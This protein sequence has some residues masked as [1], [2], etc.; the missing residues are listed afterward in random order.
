MGLDMAMIEISCL[1]PLDILLTQG[2][3]KSSTFIRIG[4]TLA[5]GGRTAR[6]SHASLVVAPSLLVESLG[7]GGTAFTSLV[8]TDQTRL[9]ARVDGRRLRLFAR[10]KDVKAGYVYRHVLGDQLAPDAWLFRDGLFAALAPHYLAEYPG[11]GRLLRVATFLPEA[12]KDRMEALS[13]SVQRKIAAGPFCSELVIALLLSIGPI[14]Q[15][16]SSPETIAPGDIEH[17]TNFKYRFKTIEDDALPGNELDETSTHALAEMLC[18]G[19]LQHQE[20]KSKTIR[21]SGW[22]ERL[23]AAGVLVNSA[24]PQGFQA[25]ERT[26]IRLQQLEYVKAYLGEVSDEFWSWYS[27]SA[28][29]MESCPEGLKRLEEA[30]ARK[31]ARD[32]TNRNGKSFVLALAMS[33]PWDGSTCGQQLQCSCSQPTWQQIQRQFADYREREMESLRLDVERAKR[34]V[35]GA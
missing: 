11:A 13:I 17:L 23:Q 8:G 24:Q 25:A 5:R 2:A 18:F 14:L 32:S 29:C 16:P 26:R 6:A 12:L 33:S 35:D 30:R 21:I 31:R 4:T 15:M 22:I 10:L 28:T 27:S 34:G 19:Q 1:K 20:L 9:F 7:D 3:G